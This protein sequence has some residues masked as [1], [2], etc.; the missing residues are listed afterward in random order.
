MHTG[1]LINK[2][3][4]FTH[5]LLHS[6]DCPLYLKKTR[7]RLLQQLYYWQDDCLV[8]AFRDIQFYSE[9]EADI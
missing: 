6:E 8:L 4:N 1:L 9:T 3:E 5:I 2:E 7:K